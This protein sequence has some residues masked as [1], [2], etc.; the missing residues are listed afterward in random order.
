MTPLPAFDRESPASPLLSVVQDAQELRGGVRKT[1]TSARDEVDVAGEIQL[2]HLHLFDPAV[3][4][5]PQ[6]AHARHDGHAHTHLDEALDALDGRHF[7]G[8]IQGRAVSGEKLDHAPAERRLDNVA[9]ESLL[10]Q[11]FVVSFTPLA[12]WLFEWHP[13]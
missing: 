8:H 11:I 10:A 4:N 7:D 12:R 3:L 1:R 9:A 2:P 6:R 13:L 5:F